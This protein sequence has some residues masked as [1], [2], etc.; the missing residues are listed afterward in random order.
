MASHK[1]ILYRQWATGHGGV[2]VPVTPDT[3]P[4]PYLEG[5]VE[6]DIITPS[7]RKLT[8][9]NPAYMSRQVYELDA[10]K[11]GLIG[12]LTSLNPINPKNKPDEWEVKAFSHISAGEK[13]FSSVEKMQGKHYFRFMSPFFV[14]KQCLSCHARYG[15]KEGDLRGGISIAINMEPLM[16][17]AGKRIGTIALSYVLLWGIALIVILL[18]YRDLQ[19]EEKKRLVAEMEKEKLITE[20]QGS[21]DKIETLSGLLPICASCKKIRNDKGY[22]ERIEKYISKRTAA[23]FTHSICPEC[24]TK[25]Y[26]EL[27]E[28]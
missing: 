4:N 27:D 6:R 26:P 3:P 11:S 17:R 24:K 14:E 20:L 1:D 16:A 21:L 15:F 2:Y 8:L 18:G 12:K 10:A 7:G 28:E 9:L 5:I 23:E 13:E 25:L 19:F 22:W